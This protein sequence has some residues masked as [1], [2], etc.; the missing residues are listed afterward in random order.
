MD[1]FPDLEEFIVVFLLR[2]PKITG[3]MIKS[4]FD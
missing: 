4:L 1:T 3:N 2:K